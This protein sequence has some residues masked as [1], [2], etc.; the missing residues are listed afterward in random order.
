MH[1]IARLTSALA[2]R[3]RIEREIGTGG[4]ATVYLAHDERHDR[5]VAIKLL[6]PDLAAALGVERF[7]AE[8][9]TTARLQH[10]HVLS[11]IDSGEADGLL[12]YV[13][14]FVA[15]ES[16]RQR[17]VREKLLPID[18]ALRLAR[19]VASALDYAHRHGVVHRDIKPENILLQ[20]GQA[21]VADFG[22]AFA[23]SAAGGSRLTQ[24]GLSLGTP[25]YMAPEQAMGERVVDA[26]ADIYPLGTVLYE[27]LVGDPPFTGSTIQAIVAKVLTE[28]PMAPSTVRD[29]VPPHV[30]RAVLTALAKLPADRFASAKD[31]A[32]ALTAPEVSSRT[33]QPAPA[34][35]GTSRWYRTTIPAW[36]VGFAALGAA[37]AVFGALRLRPS[38]SPSLPVR[39]SLEGS[40]S[41]RIADAIPALSPDGRLL[42][43]AVDSGRTQTRNRG[44]SST[45]L[46]VRRLDQFTSTALPGT[47]GYSTGSPPFISTDGAW[48]AFVAGGKLKKVRLDGASQAEI[49]ADASDLPVGGS[50]FPDGSIAFA[51]DLS[52]GLERVS[53]GRP[54]EVLTTPDRQAGE[55]GVGFPEV[56]PDGKTIVF[57]LLTQNGWS[58]AA[59]SLTSKRQTV[60]IPG[61]LSARY[62]APGYL[63]YAKN[64]ALHA[65]KFDPD[66]LTLSG[67]PVLLEPSLA[68]DL[69]GGGLYGFFAVSQSGTLAYIPGARV[70]PVAVVL[71]DRQGVASPLREAVG[72]WPRFSPNGQSLAAGDSAQIWTYDLTR[73]G[74]RT[75]LTSGAPRYVPVWSPDGARVVY[76]SYQ[77]GPANLYITSLANPAEARRLLPGDNRRYAGSWSR[78]GSYLTYVEID[79]RTNGDIW[80]LRMDTSA[81][82]APAVQTEFREYQPRFSLDGKWL[83]YTSNQSG[84]AE[85]YVQG[86]PTAGRPQ[87]ISI[88]G[89]RS[90][91]WS[92]DGRELYFQHGQTL[93]V[94]PVSAAGF[95][96]ARRLFDVPRMAQ[97]DDNGTPYDISPDGKHFAVGVDSLWAPRQ[98]NVVVNW[99]PR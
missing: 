82:P 44:S 54:P 80:V 19:E 81:A 62:A 36:W 95:G 69:R 45:R 71:V 16:L 56:L 79:P 25:Q 9:K 7:L 41:A 67:S 4:M 63:V 92:H 65:V 68:G 42:V 6:H 37:A 3:Y 74:T 78:D 91:V 18:H 20:E 59:L 88:D 55:I 75:R 32:D 83:A 40:A 89:G 58:V 60:L 61:A 21:L 87:R 73:G 43:Y 94:V 57:G 29:T 38:P 15:G 72:D 97:G 8:I 64:G 53:A 23:V 1:T 49:I 26:R 10:P 14:P 33:T 52:K 66:Q 39:F 99:L 35:S 85:V 2:G 47:E 11:L 27:M 48:V 5:E 50:W 84:R 77:S 90:P 28:R 86:F 93:M 51:P 24:T 70:P 30:E 17:L 31:F 96:E 12:Y 98:L 46:F 76:S 13:M 34:K 22:I